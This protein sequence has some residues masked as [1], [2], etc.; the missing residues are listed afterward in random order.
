VWVG[1]A[2]GQIGSPRYLINHRG[3]SVE[4]RL[5][6]GYLLNMASAELGVPN[7]LITPGGQRDG[8]KGQTFAL[9]YSQPPP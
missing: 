4:S 9:V 3:Y 8:R 2:H 1:P 6:R 5:V 7:L